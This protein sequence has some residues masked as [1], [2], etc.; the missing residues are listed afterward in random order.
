MDTDCSC[1]ALSVELIDSLI[2][3]K[4]NKDP[5]GEEK[6]EYIGTNKFEEKTTGIF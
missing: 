3:R 2:K 6:A 1:M 5:Y 4:M